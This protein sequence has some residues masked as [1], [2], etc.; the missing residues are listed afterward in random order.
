ME[1]RP[2]W[3]FQGVWSLDLEY[4]AVDEEGWSYAQDMWNLSDNLDKHS[5]L[6]KATATCWTRR[7]KWIRV[8][9]EKPRRQS[10]TQ[11]AHNKSMGGMLHPTLERTSSMG[12]AD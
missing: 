5:S 3:A 10:L 11:G 8:Q 9:T 4:T 2:G 1:P 6:G 7:R 12:T